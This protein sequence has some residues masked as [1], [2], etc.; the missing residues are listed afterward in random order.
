MKMAARDKFK[1][2]K[3]EY[4]R[5]LTTTTEQMEERIREAEKEGK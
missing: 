5:K 4:S 3:E 2:I 1:K